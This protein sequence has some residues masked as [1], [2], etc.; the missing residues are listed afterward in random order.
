MRTVIALTTIG[1]SFALGTRLA[2]QCPD[3]SP[4]PC[5]PAITRS[6]SID[7]TAVAIFPFQVVGSPNDIGW[8][9]EGGM[10]LLAIA[11]EAIG[12]WRVLSGRTVL[13]HTAELTNQ[14]QP[15]EAS[16]IARSIGAGRLVLSRAVS[17]GADLVVT[18][19][20]YDTKGARRLASGTAR[21]K[22]TNPG[23]LIDSLA[24][25]LVSQ[26]I[27]LQMRRPSVVEFGTAAPLALRAYLA[28]EQLIRV[29]KWQ[30]AA[31]SLR[32]SIERDSTF[33]M[34]WYRLLLTGW[35]AGAETG[36]GGDVNALTKGALR[37]TTRLPGRIRLVLGA[38]QAADRGERLVALRRADELLTAFPDDPD[39]VLA[40]ADNYY[41][42]GLF[43]GESP[44]RV[45]GVFERALALDAHL[46][47][48]YMHLADMYC[49]L[50]DSTGTWK[51]FER[52]QAALPNWADG[53]V[54]RIGMRAVFR[55]EDPARLVN[56]VSDADM[57]A[58]GGL[59]PISALFCANADPARAIAIADSFTAVVAN[60]DRTRTLHVTATAR[61]HDF[62]LARGQYRGAWSVLQ[63]AAAVE[64]G[65]FEV[66]G[67]I[68]LHHLITGTKAREAEEAARHLSGR[69]GHPLILLLWQRAN[70]QLLDSA[71]TQR[72]R[73]ET[74]LSR[75][76]M[77]PY[78]EALIA[79]LRGLMLL[80]TGDSTAARRQLLRAYEVR[81]PAG[82]LGTPFWGKP[83][84]R[85]TLALARLE[86]A[87]GDL[88]AALRHLED[89][90]L[91]LGTL[92]RA[93]AEE[94]RGQLQEKRGD[95][96]AAVQAYRNFIALW[97]DADPELEPR[98]AAARA[99][100]ARIERR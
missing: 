90:A 83:D 78:R 3:G 79:G 34:A 50:R 87:A 2:A 48:A 43:S 17:T 6:P 94:L 8:I 68:I 71:E 75:E 55:S 76:D 66:A 74:F 24:T 61:R 21:G 70:A 62:Y 41:H 53:R 82:W 51:A 26:R 18:G 52:Q 31:D 86:Y 57:A 100:L 65:R 54:Y 59:L 19:E 4:P 64:P 42:Y 98:V 69:D 67:R 80:N 46:P 63:K 13:A 72:L 97:Q 92:E 84:R 32:K 1:L 85:F 23:A 39:A 73:T 95:T 89:M 33:G 9:R 99:A 15:A 7:T 12:A 49:L 77:G 91:P 10:D 60:S 45:L 29:G 5:K 35:W 11:F 44:T 56:E 37:D 36:F 38:I 96:T 93:E 14:S 47:E 81:Y 28:A 20:L 30:A 27:A 40:A 88:E 22:S 25:A 58:H 16:R